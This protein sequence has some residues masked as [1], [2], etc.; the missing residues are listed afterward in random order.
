MAKDET[1]GLELAKKGG[2]YSPVHVVN[3][4]TVGTVF[5]GVMTIVL[6]VAYLRVLRKNREL[7]RQLLIA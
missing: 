1:A 4:D 6:L 3:N 5:L 7:E 2:N